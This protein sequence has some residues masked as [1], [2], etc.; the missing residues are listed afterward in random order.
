MKA[1]TIISPA[2]GAL[3]PLTGETT[4]NLIANVTDAEHPDAQLSY[5]WQTLL[6]HNNHEHPNPP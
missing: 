6:H 1:V 3:F 5:Q 4:Y 2:T